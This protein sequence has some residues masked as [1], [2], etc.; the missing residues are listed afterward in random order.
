MVA[1]SLQHL[2][3]QCLQVEAGQ[4]FATHMPS[5][6]RLATSTHLLRLHGP[7][8]DAQH[9]QQDEDVVVTSTSAIMA[10]HPL[11]STDQSPSEQHLQSAAM[12]VAVAVARMTGGKT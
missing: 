3:L 6:V 12:M 8:L 10:A 11:L 2:H 4:Q 1:F 5:L 9:P 7:T